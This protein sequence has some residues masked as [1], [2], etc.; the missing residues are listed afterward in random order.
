MAEYDGLETNRQS[1][2]FGPKRL[3][4]QWDMTCFFLLSL[5]E[6][7]LKSPPSNIRPSG[8]LGYL[9]KL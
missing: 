1:N 9:H 4:S 5:L 3:N 8:I 2:I 7:W 6:G